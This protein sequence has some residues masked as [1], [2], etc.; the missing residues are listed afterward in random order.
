MEI[1]TVAELCRQC[2]ASQTDVGNLMNFRKT[3]KTSC[4]KWRSAVVKVCGVLGCE[5]ADIFPDHLEHEVIT[6]KISAFVERAQLSPSSAQM[7]DPH[8]EC[9]KEDLRNTLDSVIETLSETQ[10]DVLRMR[11]LEGRTC[12]EIA[13]IK[14]ISK[15]SVNQTEKLAL[16]GM[17]HPERLREL[18]DFVDGGILTM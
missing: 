14:G 3:A 5:P 1:K 6:N 7:L 13:D 11:F 12:S 9:V 15:S 17:R 10:R 2:G 4:G 16:K 18:R 8:E